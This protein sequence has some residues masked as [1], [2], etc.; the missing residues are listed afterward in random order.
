MYARL[1]KEYVES[2]RFCISK[3]DNSEIA[4]YIVQTLTNDGVLKLA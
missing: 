3:L 1:S 4:N 2:K